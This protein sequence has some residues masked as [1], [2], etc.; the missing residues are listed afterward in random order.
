M[1]DLD[2]TEI[3]SNPVPEDEMKTPVATEVYLQQLNPDLWQKFLPLTSVEIMD[4]W[5]NLAL[6]H[7][8]DFKAGETATDKFQKA[9]E[10]LLFL[11]YFRAKKARELDPNLTVKSFSFIPE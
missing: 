1:T 3:N 6:D 10:E 9:E 8:H 7:I 2:K 4:Y 5:N 11:N